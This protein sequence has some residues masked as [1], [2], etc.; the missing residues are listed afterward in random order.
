MVPATDDSEQLIE[1]EGGISITYRLRPHCAENKCPAIAG[2]ILIVVLI[3]IGIVVYGVV[4]GTKNK[5]P[6]S[7]SVKG[8]H[9]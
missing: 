2:I 7:N 6:K 9:F 3:V 1:E 4:S 8:T 5:S